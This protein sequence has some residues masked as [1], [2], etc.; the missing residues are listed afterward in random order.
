MRLDGDEITHVITIGEDVTEWHAVQGQ[1]LQAEKLA[2][3]GQLAA[4]VMHEINNPLATISACV[5]AIQGRLDDGGTATRRQVEEYLR[6]HRHGGRALQPDRGRAARLQPPQGDGASAG[7]AERRGGRD[8]LPAQAPPAVQA[9]RR[10]C[11]SWRPGCPAHLGSAEQLIQV[12]MALHA[13]RGWTRWSR[14]ASSTVRTGREPGAGPTRWWSRWQDTGIGHSPGGPD[15]DLRAVLHH[16]AAG[17]GHRAR[18]LHLLRDRRGPPRPDRGGQRTRPGRAPSGSSC[19][20]R[21]HEDPGHRGRPH[22]RPVREAR[23]GGAAL[24][25]RPGGRRDGGAA[26]RVGRA[27]RPDRAR[28]PAARA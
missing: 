21:A 5:A 28:P 6:D 16:Q 17:A 2:A 7:A 14:A 12:L 10:W 15:Q 4:G 20:S 26:A 25:G 1:I 18:T 9:A 11:A 8:A 24:P 19:R 13:Q 22:R 23:A 27:V 3:I